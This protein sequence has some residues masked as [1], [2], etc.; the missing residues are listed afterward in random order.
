[1][2]NGADWR[3]LNQTHVNSPVKQRY[4]MGD[5][6][7]DKK[8]QNLQSNILGAEEGSSPSYNQETD[9]AAFGSDANWTS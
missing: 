8:Y 1:M 5:S 4:Q 7:K 2:A 9:K 3:N 6:T